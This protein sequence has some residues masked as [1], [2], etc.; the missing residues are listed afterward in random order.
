MNNPIKEQILSFIV[1]NFLFGESGD[2]LK[3]TDSFLDTGIID[4]TGVL[5]IVSYI[6][7][8]YGFQVEDE[9]LIPENLDS[10]ANVATYIERKQTQAVP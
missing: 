3:E 4:S 7:E 8:T 1:E 10:I 5:E 6:E 2:D 9:D